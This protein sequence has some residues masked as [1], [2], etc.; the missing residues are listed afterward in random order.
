MER[1]AKS[2]CARTC[3]ESA[4]LRRVD[5]A[6]GKG[7]HEPFKLGSTSHERPRV[8]CVDDAA[9]HQLEVAQVAEGGEGKAG[10]QR[11]EGEA[12]ALDGI[13][14]AV[15]RALQAGIEPWDASG[16][17]DNAL[18]GPRP[19]QVHGAAAESCVVAIGLGGQKAKHPFLD[20]GW[21]QQ[22]GQAAVRLLG[23]GHG[24]AQIFHFPR[25]F[26]WTFGLVVD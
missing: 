19:Q 26:S 18:D 25:D 20:C 3:Q 1:E 12:E 6:A 8:L 9:A 10:A 7:D 13:A 22:E 4:R 24:V 14:A 11:S 21:Q 16:L 15:E 17:K 5:L 23:G 2:T